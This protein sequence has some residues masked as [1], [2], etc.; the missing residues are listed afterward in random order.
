MTRWWWWWVDREG[1]GSS[2]HPH[3]MP[4]QLMELAMLG[5]FPDD[6]ICW[7]THQEDSHHLHSHGFEIG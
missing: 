6:D 7:E 2:R 1:E 5:C 4:E 3:E